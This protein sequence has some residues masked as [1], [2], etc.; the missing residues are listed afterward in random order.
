MEENRF[1]NMPEGNDFDGNGQDEKNNS[2]KIE[3]N[4][5]EREAAYAFRWNY[6][7]QDGYNAAKARKERKNGIKTYAIVMTAA[8]L[9]CFAILISVIAL[10]GFANITETKIIEHVRTIFVREYDKESGVLTVPEIAEKVTPGVVGIKVTYDSGISV[11]TGIIMSEDGHIATN[12]HVVENAKSVKV[13]FFD[14]DE[15]D[16]RIVGV[17]ALSDL[18]VIDIDGEE[19]KKVDFGNSDELIVG[20]VAVAIGTP[21]GLEFAGT[22][23]S[24]IISAINRDVKIFDEATGALQ[25]TMTL[26]Q[27]SASINKGNSG[28]PLI[29]DR[30]QVIGINTLKLGNGYDGIG[31]AIPINGALEILNKI[32]EKGGDI[33]ENNTAIAKKRAIIGIK[34][35]AVTKAQGAP[36]TGVY[37]AEISAGYDAENHLKVGDIIVGINGNEVLQV[38]DISAVIEDMTAGDKVTLKIYRDGNLFDVDIVLDYEK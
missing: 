12:A 25:K 22:V 34:G 23:T 24:G 17:D 1:E 9:L 36:A 5:Q 3:K 2:E 13:I 35:G 4:E 28:G 31:F 21:A 27:T 16:G 32:I 15:I 8:F 6:E 37:V 19:Y 20:E 7:E 10:D 26:I 14:G 38:S 30:G 11:G 18:A 33:S 29:N